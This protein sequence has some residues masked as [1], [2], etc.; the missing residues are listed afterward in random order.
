[1]MSA[2]QRRKFPPLKL[3]LSNVLIGAIAGALFGIGFGALASF[4]EGGPE[5]LTGIKES[6]L[7][8]TVMGAIFGFSGLYPYSEKS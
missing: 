4:F 6:W 8:F 1:M 5:L 3:L 7:W 2:Y